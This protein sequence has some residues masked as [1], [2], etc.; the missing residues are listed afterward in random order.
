VPRA[1]TV[2]GISS[3]TNFNGDY[4]PVTVTAPR[5]FGISFRA[6]FGSR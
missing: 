3:A 1:T 4:V 5:E 6:A 2:R